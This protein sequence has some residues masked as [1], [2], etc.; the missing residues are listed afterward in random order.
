MGR[1]LY[2]LSASLMV[3]ALLSCGLAYTNVADQP[4]SPGDASMWRT[5]GLVL[6][7][8]ALVSALGGVLTTLF[9]QAE[10]RSE[11]LRRGRRRRP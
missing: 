2:I 8:M 5:M 10:R 1:N 6:F 9:E 11:Q 4:G 3:F 7:V